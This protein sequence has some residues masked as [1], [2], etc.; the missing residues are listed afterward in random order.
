MQQ[1]DDDDYD[2][3]EIQSPELVTPRE[4]RKKEFKMKVKEGAVPEDD[5]DWDNDHPPGKKGKYLRSS[6]SA[7]A[8]TCILS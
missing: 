5:L 7:V 3:D 8:A 4:T 1:S 2:Y 6:S